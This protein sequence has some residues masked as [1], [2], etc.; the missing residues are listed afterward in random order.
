MS[1]RWAGRKGSDVWGFSVITGS[2]AVFWYVSNRNIME[3]SANQGYLL[4]SRILRSS[5]AG[6]LVLLFSGT[7]SSDGSRHGLKAPDFE[8]TF[9]V[10]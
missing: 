10:C 4:S 6:S 2:M 3:V 5:R 7:D 9:E 1:E 8:K